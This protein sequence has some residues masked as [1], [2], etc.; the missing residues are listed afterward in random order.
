MTSLRSLAMVGFMAVIACTLMYLFTMKQVTDTGGP[1]IAK[2]VGAMLSRSLA[3]EAPAKMTV[4]KQGTGSSTRRHYVLTLTP[5]EAV[6]ANDKAVIRLLSRAAE[7]VTYELG[8]P[9]KSVTITCVARLS[10]DERRASF[11]MYGRPTEEPAAPASASASADA[12]G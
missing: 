12:G 7:L 9:K 11:D 2:K 4:Y 6:A 5:S 10:D 8:A 1:A 3:A